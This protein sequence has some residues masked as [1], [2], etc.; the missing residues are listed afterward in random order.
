MRI[1]ISLLLITFGVAAHGA[2]INDSCQTQIPKQLH[3]L[4]KQKFPGYRAPM[5][6]DNA[7]GSVEWDLKHGGKGCLG[8]AIADFDGDNSK[9]FL[10]GLTSLRNEGALV[11]VAL[12]RGSSWNFHTLYRWKGGRNSLYVAVKEP[13]HFKRTG[14]LDG[15]LG[16]GE[17]ESMDC[18]NWGALFGATESSGV[19]YCFTSG[20]WQHIWI[21]D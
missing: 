18:A 20:K 2:P 5:A 4:L 6:T 3:T 12:E 7:S 13:G 9:D 17:K 15:P 21:S 8:V 19:V 1:I 11:V 10:L 14:S 16:K